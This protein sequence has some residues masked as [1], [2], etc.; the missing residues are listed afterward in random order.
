MWNVAEEASKNA[1]AT[2]IYPESS[3]K[4]KLKHQEQI[5]IGGM[6][7]LAVDDGVFSFP[8]L[9]CVIIF[10]FEFF[11]CGGKGVVEGRGILGYLNFLFLLTVFGFE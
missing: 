6:R 4:S 11:F 5:I 7:N 9:F 1:K 2:Q 10:H 3:T 8:F